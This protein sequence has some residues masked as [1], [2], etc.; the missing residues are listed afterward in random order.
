[1]GSHLVEP[2]AVLADRFVVEDLIAEEGASNS[3]RAHD[4]ILARSVVLQILPTAAPQAAEMLRAAK[5]ASR[6][7][8]PRLLQV[9]DAVD[10]GELSYVV[11]EW[12]AG[13]SLNVMLAEGPLSARRSAWLVSEVAAAM[14]IAHVTGL[15]HR[16]LAPDTVVV[17]TS[18]GVKVVGLGTFAALRDTQADDI[19]GEVHDTRDLG[20]LLY[21]CLTARWP[22]SAIAG[23]PAAPSHHGRLLRPRQVRAGVPRSLDAVCDRILSDSSR[24]GAQITTAA[25]VRD[26]LIQI[27]A[28][29]GFPTGVGTI[30]A[31]AAPDSGAQLP[32]DPPP[33]LLPR[34]AGP[35]PGEQPPH[36]PSTAERRR[37]PPLRRG[38]MLIVAT[39]LIAGIA[40]LA[41]LIGQRG[42]TEPA[43]NADEPTTSPQAT[44]DAVEPLTVESAS[45][46]DPPPQG[47]G[48]ENPGLVPFATDGDADTSWETVTYNDQ[49]GPTLPSLKEGVGLVLDLG[50]VQP[51][52]GVQLKTPAPGTDLEIRTAPTAATT[53]PQSSIDEYSVARQLVDDAQQDTR[54]ML[55]EPVRTRF[56]LV[57]LTKLPA[58]A[59]GGFQ[60]SISEVQVLG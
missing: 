22:G 26:E 13:Q 54:V 42:L 12:A 52:R 2:G 33:A 21:S 37:S 50:Q 53:V 18:S 34:A 9:L 15:S 30:A 58:A 19:A 47:S 45:S 5:Q 25:E 11:R 41:F 32:I 14:C 51:V 20:R 55:D 39:L 56:V 17:T 46:F 40:S 16:R 31:T 1:V 36:A 44:R 57:W 6:V 27:L 43:A 24:Y 48:D 60:G 59:T 10:D 35:P 29:E 38:L 7:A 3:W 28:A 49:L 4:K 8:D 23:L